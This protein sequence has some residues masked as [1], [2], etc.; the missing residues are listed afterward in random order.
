MAETP[1][2]P[3]LSKRQR[4]KQRR[5]EKVQAQQQ[6][7]QAARRK[8]TLAT[9]AIVVLLVGAAGA[10]GYGW[11]SDRLEERRLIAAAEERHGELGC[12]P[13]EEEP[14]APSP[15]L[16][17][18][19]DLRNN[20][21]EVLYDV[22]P[23]TSGPHLGGVAQT[24]VYDKV[25]DERLL[26][27][28]L[29]HGYVNIF[30][31]P[32]APA[33]QVDALKDFAREQI[34]SRRHEKIIVSQWKAELDGDAHFALTAWGARQLCRDFDEGVALAFLREYHY[35]AGSAP[36]RELRPH[37]DEGTDPDATDGDVLFPPLAEAAAPEDTMDD[38]AD[39]ADDPAE[40]A[41]DGAADEDAD[42]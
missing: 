17:S 28:N 20:P 15:H 4:Q 26:L 41:D 5:Q 8:R 42:G 38:P 22:R 33:E 19:E 3:Q 27:H 25:I 7:A 13:I 16:Q 14:I 35:L 12:T 34:D 32:D 37:L 21:P 6:A 31:L 39:D 36:E 23:A 11:A 29:E 9:V 18:E 1:D 2:E 40:D 24:G 10:F 30:Y